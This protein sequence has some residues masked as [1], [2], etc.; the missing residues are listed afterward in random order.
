M[1]LKIKD[2]PQEKWGK[3]RVYIFPS[4]TILENLMNRRERPAKQWKKEILPVVLGRLGIDMSR[5]KIRWS[6]YAGCS[7]PC[8][9]GFILDGH[10]GHD[11]FVDVK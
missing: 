4:E 6:Q 5:V 9:P 7:C 11:I 8:S 3:T 10:R 1:N 2:R